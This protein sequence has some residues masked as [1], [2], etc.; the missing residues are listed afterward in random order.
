MSISN[1]EAQDI[2]DESKKLM[3]QWNGFIHRGCTGVGGCKTTEERMQLAWTAVLREVVKEM[4]TADCTEVGVTM[5]VLDTLKEFE[6][7]AMITAPGSNS[8]H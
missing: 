3:R 7:D 8:K 6:E 5:M 4:R 2:C 1:D